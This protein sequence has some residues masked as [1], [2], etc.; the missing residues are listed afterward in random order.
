MTITFK[1]LFMLIN[2]SCIMTLFFIL[3]MELEFLMFFI[4]SL[5]VVIVLCDIND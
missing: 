5:T 4:F 1:I 2:T 3:L